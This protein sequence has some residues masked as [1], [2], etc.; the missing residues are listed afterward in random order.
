MRSED[1]KIGPPTDLFFITHFPRHLR[2]YN[3]HPSPENESETHSFDV[4]FRGCEICTGCQLLHSHT[5]LRSAMA[6]RKH[7]IDHDSSQWRPFVKAHDIG[8]PPWGGFGRKSSLLSMAV[9]GP[10]INM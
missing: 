4:I 7:P 9:S 3:V 1:S 2:P 8:M 5:E 6:A 10:P